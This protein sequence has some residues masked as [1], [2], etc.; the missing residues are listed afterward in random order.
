[1]V[2]DQTIID[3]IFFW[4]KIQKLAFNIDS[5]IPLRP[6]L[7]GLKKAPERL[8]NATSSCATKHA[9]CRKLHVVHLI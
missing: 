6:N 3:S 7:Q 2:K 9:E 8:V 4:L 5:G 1:M